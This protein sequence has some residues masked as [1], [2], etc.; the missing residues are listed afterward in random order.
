MLFALV[1]AI[2]TVAATNI[3][4]ASIGGSGVADSPAT[5]YKPAYFVLLAL[6][7]LAITWSV[8]VLIRWWHKPLAGRADA[9]AE[10]S[11][12][13]SSAPIVPAINLVASLLTI[14]GFVLTYIL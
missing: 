8:P 2:P 4:W 1:L 3:L 6:V 9:T 13:R 11:A 7:G 5:F 14:L 10:A 12:S